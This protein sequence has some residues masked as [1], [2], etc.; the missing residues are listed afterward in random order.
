MNVWLWDAVG[1]AR[2]A[3]GV[4]D[5]EARARLDAEAV[6]IAGHAATARVERAGLGLG[7]GS[8]TYGYQRT[9]QAWHARCSNGRVTWEP[10]PCTAELAA[11]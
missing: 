3:C 2:T 1:P 8:M 7:A 9:G 11:S 5:R 4:T 6:L 10:V